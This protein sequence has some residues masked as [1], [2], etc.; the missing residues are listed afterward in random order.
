MHMYDGIGIREFLQDTSEKPPPVNIGKALKVM[1]FPH[2]LR[3]SI[4]YFWWGRIENC[5]LV[6]LDI[7][8]EQDVWFGIPLVV[9]LDQ[10]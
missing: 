8:L 4:Q 2:N 9:Q 7:D 1:E 6:V 5:P 10:R 3:K